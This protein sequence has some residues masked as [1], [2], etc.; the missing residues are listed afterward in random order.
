MFSGVLH[1]GLL[2]RKRSS[3][4]ESDVDSPYV[5]HACAFS[6]DILHDNSNKI[7]F[8]L[9]YFNIYIVV[10]MLHVYKEMMS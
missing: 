1:D 9:S 2:E 3:A 6:L 4:A 7:I 10:T 5:V 8:Q